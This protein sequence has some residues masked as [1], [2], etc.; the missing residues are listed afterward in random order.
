MLGF[1][2]HF[3]QEFGSFVALLSGR[4]N[5]GGFMATTRSNQPGRTQRNLRQP[6]EMPI[7]HT[8]GGEMPDVS[9]QHHVSEDEL[10][11]L[12]DVEGGQAQQGWQGLK[13]LK[14]KMPS[15]FQSNKS[16]LP[17]LLGTVGLGFGIF[18]LMRRY[19]QSQI[20]EGDTI[21]DEG[22]NALNI[23]DVQPSRLMGA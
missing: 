15:M 18:F 23:D 9:E 7:K 8:P 17:L 1:Y 6:D 12:G 13:N 21:S 2:D 11:V 14:D 20:Q 4:I 16:Y 19:N 5:P 10:E 22:K 3:R